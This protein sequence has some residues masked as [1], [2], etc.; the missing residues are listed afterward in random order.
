MSISRRTKVAFLL[1]LLVMISVAAGFVLGALAAKGV[2]KKKDDPRVWKKAAMNH[3][4]RLQPTDEQ[5]K[6]FEPRVDSAVEELVAIRKDTVTRAEAAV[7]RAVTDVEQELTPEQREI[8]AKI[9]P[10]PKPADAE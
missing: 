1:V 3:L 7:A 6:K 8:F 9:K 2:A 10:K 5:G 4:E